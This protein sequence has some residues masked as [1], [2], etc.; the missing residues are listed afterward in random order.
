MTST[1]NS[2]RV[3]KWHAQLEEVVTDGTTAAEPPLQKAVVAVVI[4]NPFAG[5]RQDDLSSLIDPSAELGQAL[6]RR[7]A[8]LLGSPVAG[9]GKGGLAGTAG[10]QEHVVACVTTTFGNAFRDAIGGGRAWIS[11]TTKVAGPGAT[12][13]VPLA[14]KDEVYVRSHY[15]AITLRIDD[16]PRPDELVIAVAVASGPRPNHRVGGMSAQEAL[17]ALTETSSR[18]APR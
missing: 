10:E 13:D 16:A 11:S 4:E 2:Y 12:L 7:A 14:F 9:Y 15:D 5:V 3:R 1:L 6:G 18:K 8:A 17:D